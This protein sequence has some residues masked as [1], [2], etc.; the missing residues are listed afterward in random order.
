MKHIVRK[1][2]VAVILVAGLFAVSDIYAQGEAE[3]GAS[4]ANVEESAGGGQPGFVKIVFQGGAV[5]LIIW[6]M[7]FGTSAAT[8]ALIIDALI[9]VK[10]DKL[11]PEELVEGVRESLDEG[12]LDA[13][14]ESCE[15]NPGPLSSILMVGF[16]NIS[17]GFDVIQDAIA[18][19]AEMETEK[20]LQRVNYLNLCGQIAP[21]LGLLGTVTGMV[22]AFGGLGGA[23]GG[24]K[25]AIL[26]SAIST[27]LWTTAVGLM[28]AV[29]AL[30]AYTLVRNHA[31]RIILEI[32][33]TVTDLIKVLRNAEVEE[34][35][36]YAEE[37]FAEEE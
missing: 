19:A 3:G 8:I 31:T 11:R 29:P 36:E 15:S 32:E 5:N 16:S 23:T 18:S 21:M 33:A 22:K 7:I 14:V 26:A 34:G 9:T 25:A 24:A 35:E 10:R 2:L 13:A 20:L 4:G 30:L 1:W 28:I 12:D 17:E 6:F 27:A 37:E